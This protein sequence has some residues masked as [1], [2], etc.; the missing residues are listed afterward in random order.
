MACNVGSQRHR[1]DA[2]LIA[3][4]AA[5]HTREQAATQAHVSARTADRRLA[6]PTFARA[7]ADA[8]AA[9]VRQALAR[10]ADGATQAADTLVSLLGAESDAIRLGA[11]RALLD[12]AVKAG[13]LLSIDERLM[14]LEAVQGA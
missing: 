4:L 14:R 10:V 7:V 2:V 1:A 9:L 13:D 11:A 5:G 3:A 12:L 8:R 6:D